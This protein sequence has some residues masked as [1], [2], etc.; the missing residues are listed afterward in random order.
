ME[1]ELDEVVVVSVVPI[2]LASGEDGADFVGGEWIA[3]AGL[4]GSFKAGESGEWVGLPEA[5]RLCPG[6]E[7][8]EE[9]EVLVCDRRRLLR[10]EMLYESFCVGGRETIASGVI[11]EWSVLSRE[12]LR[13]GAC[14]AT[15][16]HPEV[17]EVA[18]RSVGLVAI[19]AVLGE[20]GVKSIEGNVRLDFGGF[21]LGDTS[22]E[23]GIGKP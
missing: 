13:L 7:G 21:A 22:V 8:L 14:G 20:G 1:E 10:A 18:D 19:V 23:W 16:V 11:A 4:V 6:A 12:G 9:G 2:V 5:H 3:G 15:G 17:E